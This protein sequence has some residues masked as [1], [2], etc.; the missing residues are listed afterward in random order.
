MSGW[1]VGGKFEVTCHAFD[2]DLDLGSLSDSLRA[3]PHC[4]D[5]VSSRCAPLSVILVRAVFKFKILLVRLKKT[6]LLLWIF[7][8]PTMTWLY[9][10][11]A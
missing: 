4:I 2:T 9:G 1:D 6:G 5:G 8:Q 10:K 11:S 3:C 7:D